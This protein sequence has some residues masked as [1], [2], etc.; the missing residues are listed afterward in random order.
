MEH[1]HR[2]DATRDSQQTYARDQPGRGQTWRCAAMRDALRR[3]LAEERSVRSDT[4]GVSE[5]IGF[6]LLFGILITALAAYQVT[7]V[8]QQNADVEFQHSAEIESDMQDLRAAVL[9][10]GTAG[11]TAQSQSVPL[12]LGTQY[13]SR[14]IAV[15]P[16]PVT[17]QLRTADRNV[18]IV[19][20]EVTTPDV[21]TGDPG[22]TLLGVGHETSRIRYRPDYEELDTPADL[23]LE[24]SL[25]YR[26][27]EDA[28]ISVTDQTLVQNSSRS[29]NIVLIDGDIEANGL[30]TSVDVQTLDGPTATV[31]I[32]ATSGSTFSINMSTTSPGVWLSSQTIGETFDTGEPNV[33]AS[34]VG[35]D[36]VTLTV[37]DSVSGDWTLQMTKVGVGGNG[38]TS[39]AFSNID[40]IDVR[41]PDIN[42]VEN[43]ATVTQGDQ[44]DISGD[45]SSLGTDTVNRTGTPIQKIRAEPDGEPN[46]VLF[47]ENPDATNRSFSFDSRDATSNVDPIDTS[48][49][50]TGDTDV[51]IRAQDASGRWSRIDTDSLTITVNP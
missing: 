23:V 39:S 12:T 47:D 7:V 6:I 40:R 16:S 38:T 19:G 49:W 4:R 25:L 36:Q 48:G 21:F 1:S 27:N 8:P 51:T 17:G 14:T 20:A 43:T 35:S 9:N 11:D 2:S 10:T 32:E 29:I 46:Q 31:P 41:G 15:N 45:V 3:L 44:V 50:S 5:L 34:R 24:H 37:N 22:A 18:A 13:P 42:I 30:S 33:R 28:N 26:S